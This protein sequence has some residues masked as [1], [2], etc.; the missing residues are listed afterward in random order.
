MSKIRAS[1]ILVQSLNEAVSIHSQ[2][3]EGTD[4][5]ILAQQNSKCPSGRNGGDL[6]EFGRGAMVKQFEDI[7]FELSVGE[8]SGPV[9]TK[10]GYH[11]I[12]RT[13]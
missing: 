8:L 11:L 2:I 12:K 6:G 9:P 1:H 4:F 13:A 7:A 5:S 3:T 10:F